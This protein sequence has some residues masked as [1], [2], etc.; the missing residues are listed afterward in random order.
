MCTNILLYSLHVCC[1]RIIFYYCYFCYYVDCWLL[2]R[3]QTIKRDILV[4]PHVFWED[5]CT[6]QFLSVIHS[7]EFHLNM[8]KI[9]AMR[10]C[11]VYE[12]ATHRATTFVQRTRRQHINLAQVRYND[13]CLAIM[14]KKS[15]LYAMNSRWTFGLTVFLS[16]IFVFHA[17]LP[18]NNL[19]VVAKSWKNKKLY[20]VRE[21]NHTQGKRMYNTLYYTIYTAA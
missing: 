14:P 7:G 10:K 2:D 6:C 5:F 19:W 8:Y 9:S 13:E 20:R 16:F 21:F 15:I 12:I 18:C 3:N 4:I 17:Q 1:F 11:V